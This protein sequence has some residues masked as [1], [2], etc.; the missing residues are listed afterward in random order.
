MYIAAIIAAGG[1]G[2]RL[3]GAQPKQLLAIGGRPVLERSVTAFLTHP[4]VDALVVALP[5][6]LADP[7][8]AYLLGT[9]KPLTIVAGG[10]R[11]QDSVAN[12]FRAIDER[13]DVVVIHDAARPFVS[14]DL[15]GRTIAAAVETGAALAALPARDTVK[16]AQPWR[17]ASAGPEGWAVAETLSRDTIFLAQTPQ[18]FRREVLRDAI[19]LGEQGG[20][21]TDEAA[22]VERAGHVVR[23]VDGDTANIKITTPEDWPLAEAIVARDPREPRDPSFLIGTGYDLHRLVDGRPLVLG[24]VAIPSPRGALGHSD[25]DVICHAVTDAV[26]GAACLGDI[27]HHF[28]DSDPRWKDALSIDLLRRAVALLST[29]G[30]AVANVDVTVILEQPKI[31]GYVDAMRASIAQALGIDAGH[32]SIKGKTNEGV[33]AVGRG[34]AIAAHAVALLRRM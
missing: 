31:R 17:P 29:R 7:P 26:L 4:S 15:I 10:P 16:R 6:D 1:R 20:D 11:R 23:L 14:A 12:A 32:A 34:E 18:A 25:A 30:L 8:P 2:Q 27:G 9:P 33:D 24:G 3:G 5:A 22:L 13:V 21:A 19:A 28:P